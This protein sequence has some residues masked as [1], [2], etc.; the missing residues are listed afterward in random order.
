MRLRRPSLLRLS[1]QFLLI[2]ALTLAALSAVLWFASVARGPIGLFSLGADTSVSFERGTAEVRH[3]YEYDV[4]PPV[5]TAEWHAVAM[6]RGWTIPVNRPSVVPRFAYS[7]GHV[8]GMGGMSTSG[9]GAT[10]S[11]ARYW[12]L[13]VPLWATMLPGLFAAAWLVFRW[14]RRRQDG[15]ARRRGFEVLASQ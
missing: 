14:D 10:V 13:H 8:I 5:P 9:G 1:G 6:S 11:P 3:V 7:G 2:I 15:A 4:A 12:L